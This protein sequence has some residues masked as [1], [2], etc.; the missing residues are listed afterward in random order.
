[1]STKIINYDINLVPRRI[2]VSGRM[3]LFVISIILFTTLVVYFYQIVQKNLLITDQLNYELAS[4][5]QKIE[6]QKK[7]NT[8]KQNMQKTINEYS[9]ITDK[10]EIIRTDINSIIATAQDKGILIN[11]I[12]F[13]E[14]GK[15]DAIIN[16]SCSIDNYS[17]YS[18]LLTQLN[19]YRDALLQTKRFKAVTRGIINSP[20]STNTV[21]FQLKK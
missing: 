5:T 4:V 2:P 14:H 13:Y 18:N 12:N 20:P 6:L 3:I 9:F 21:S 1:M 19:S 16:I 8:D 11:S 15:D 7:A 10:K 17:T